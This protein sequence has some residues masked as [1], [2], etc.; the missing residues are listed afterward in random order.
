[1][2]T[3]FTIL[4]CSALLL[5]AEVKNIKKTIP[6]KETQTV[7]LS[8]FNGSTLEIKS[9][10]KNEVSINISIDYS[11][12]DKENEQEYI[13]MVDVVQEDTDERMIIMYHEPKTRNNGFSL[14]NLL[15]FQFV[16]YSNLKVTGEIYVPASHNIEADL[17]YG[18]YSLEGIMG[19]LVLTGV[20]NTLRLANCAS[21]KK[22]NN[23][24]GKTT[25][26]RSGGTL[27]L[28]G[29][30]STISINDFH[31]QVIADA[32]YS[33]ISFSG[34]T[35]NTTVTCVSGKIDIDG[36][37]GNVVLDAKYSDIRLEK[38]KGT[39]TIESQSGTIRVKEVFGAVIDA[40]YSNITLESVT[41]TGNPIF[42]NN[43]SGEITIFNST[44]D[45][46]IEDSYSKVKLE[47]IQGNVT[48]SGK[49]SSFYGKRIVGNL[50]VR[51]EYGNVV[52]D[53]LSAS[54]VEISNTSN[55][56][57]IGLIIKPSKVYITNQYG[58]VE[59]SFP[60]FSGDVKLK[61]SYGSI[62]TN[63]PIEI[64]ELAGGEIAMGK[65]GSGNGTVN[66][67]TTSGNIEIHQ[68]K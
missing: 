19:N 20:S 45:V 57:E 27:V 16:S 44:R 17:R 23:N 11:S 67:K 4:I 32:N 29:T 38:L 58:S 40:P 22:I 25:I 54:T 66:I 30:S 5:H 43:T 51:N 3:V 6:I 48:L 31:G 39:A 26:E 28:E 63:L 24:Y 60:E 10:D 50:I 34:I 61:A 7:E 56:V 49:S 21:I 33:T 35:N 12:S 68:N 8:D 18:N 9:W 36:I 13:Q 65:V 14:K 2:K 55:T 59:L 1:M 15:S 53:E 52:F 37:D 46:K 47:N 62:R 42:I 64:E 41:G